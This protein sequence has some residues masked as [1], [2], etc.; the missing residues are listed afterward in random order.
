MVYHIIV[1]LGR[2]IEVSLQFC[3]FSQWANKRFETHSYLAFHRNYLCGTERCPIS[4]DR[5]RQAIWDEREMNVCWWL[6]IC[7]LPFMLPSSVYTLLSMYVEH[8]NYNALLTRSPSDNVYLLLG[9]AAFWKSFETPFEGSS[10][11]VLQVSKVT[12]VMQWKVQEYWIV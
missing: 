6:K 4:T 9:G 11:T 12:H 3:Y 5:W 1:V 8:W 7:R 2:Y 10:S